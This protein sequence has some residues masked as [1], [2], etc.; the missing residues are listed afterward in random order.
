VIILQ[1]RPYVN[2]TLLETLSNKI[3]F[4][5]E[6]SHRRHKLSKRS[7]NVKRMRHGL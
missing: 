3:N 6:S 2:L 1:A 5:L 4:P 7:F